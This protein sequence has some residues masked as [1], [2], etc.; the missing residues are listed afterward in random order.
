M[1]NSVASQL[2]MSTIESQMKTGEVTSWSLPGGGQLHIER[3]QAFL[4]LYRH[5]NSRVDTGTERLLTTQT[6]Y[7]I[8][9]HR[10]PSPATLSD[11]IK[12]IMRRSREI[13][14]PPYC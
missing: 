3:P 12:T 2:D 6:S 5:P 14:V 13:L 8:A 10:Q 11:L 9:A 7:L 1:K 4:C